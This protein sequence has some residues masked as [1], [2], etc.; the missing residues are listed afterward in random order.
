MENGVEVD[1]YP[2]MELAHPAIVALK[3]ANPE[4]NYGISIE[5]PGNP[6]SEYIPP[7]QPLSTGTQPI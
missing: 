1:S 6:L 5:G 3:N 4:K 7:T 2:N